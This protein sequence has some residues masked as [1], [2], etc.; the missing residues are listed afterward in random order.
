MCN[1]QFDNSQKLIDKDAEIDSRLFEDDKPEA[2]EIIEFLESIRDLAQST[3]NPDNFA[4]ALKLFQKWKVNLFAFYG[5]NYCQRVS[6]PAHDFSLAARFSN[7]KEWAPLQP[8]LKEFRHAVRTR[9]FT[10]QK[11]ARDTSQNPPSSRI[12]REEAASLRKAFPC[13]GKSS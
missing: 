5:I 8:E 10:T 3:Q 7:G 11:Q 2:R 6:R 1:H 12:S 4:L 9:D 13:F